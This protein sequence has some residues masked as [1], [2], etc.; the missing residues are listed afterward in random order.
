M[1][2]PL[3]NEREVLVDAVYEEIPVRQ[4]G[5]VVAGRPSRE[6]SLSDVQLGHAFSVRVHETDDLAI[7]GLLRAQ[8]GEREESEVF[9]VHFER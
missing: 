9:A 6:R 7:L 3:R 5:Q 4:A 8:V 1:H 2:R